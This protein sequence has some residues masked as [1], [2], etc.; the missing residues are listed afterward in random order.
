[1]SVAYSD[2]VHKSGRKSQD[3]VVFGRLLTTVCHQAKQSQT[4]QIFSTM[5]LYQLLK[6]LLVI[7]I[8]CGIRFTAQDQRSVVGFLFPQK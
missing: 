4:T 8:C 1:M 6:L 3:L 2:Q 5:R 7:T